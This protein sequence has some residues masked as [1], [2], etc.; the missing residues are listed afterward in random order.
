MQINDSQRTHGDEDHEAQRILK[1][2]A[3]PALKAAYRKHVQEDDRI[4][5]QELS[6][7]LI[8]A[9]CACLGDRGFQAWLKE[10]FANDKGR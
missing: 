2:H 3:I 8:D 6:D 4:G 9:L 1:Q 10:G 7:T 5:W